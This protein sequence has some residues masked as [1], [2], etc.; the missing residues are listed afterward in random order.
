MVKQCG[1]IDTLLMKPFSGCSP[2][3]F[4]PLS[5]KT[6][7]DFW[8]KTIEVLHSSTEF[9]HTKNF[10]YCMQYLLTF[11]SHFAA[12]IFCQKGPKMCL[13]ELTGK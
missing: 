10:F 5:L 1:N 4:L 7:Q 12:W 2:F 9:F 11:L 3:A 13:E 8:S 6:M